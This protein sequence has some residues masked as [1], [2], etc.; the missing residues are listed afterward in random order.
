M[1]KAQELDVLVAAG[2]VDNWTPQPRFKLV[3]NGILVG[4]YIADFRVFFADHHTEWWEVK[5]FETEVWKLKRKL[6]EALFGIKIVV[7]KS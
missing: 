4:T 5:G 3:V 7:V 1:A 6:V 2:V